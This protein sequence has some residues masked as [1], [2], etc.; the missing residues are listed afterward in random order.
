MST[1]PIKMALLEQ[2]FEPEN[3]HNGVW[4]HKNGVIVHVVAETKSVVIFKPGEDVFTLPQAMA[5]GFLFMMDLPELTK[6]V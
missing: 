2:G 6:P 5:P 4:N 3:K 1:Y